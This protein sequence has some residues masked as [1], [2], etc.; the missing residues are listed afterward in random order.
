MKS[1]KSIEALFSHMQRRH[2]S[3]YLQL[4]TCS[5]NSKVSVDPQ[6]GTLHKL[7]PFEQA[8]AAN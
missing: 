3:L 7:M 2:C 1:A 4:A 8:F 5:P 6:T